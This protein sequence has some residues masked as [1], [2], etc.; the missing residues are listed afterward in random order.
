VRTDRGGGRGPARAARGGGPRGPGHASEMFLALSYVTA[1]LAQQQKATPAS[2]SLAGSPDARSGACRC[3]PG[4]RGETCSEVDLD[5]SVPVVRQGNWSWG[6]SPI[7]G[8]GGAVH[9]FVSVMA[10]GCGLLHYQTNSVV[11]H[12]VSESGAA[13]P[14]ERRGIAL[15]P[16]PG[17]W[18]S[19]AIHGPSIHYDGS[20]GLY[21]LFHAGFTH[22]GPKPNCTQDPTFPVVMVS[23]T[24]RIGVAWSASLDGPWER[25]DPILGPGPKGSWDSTDVSNAAP[26]VLPNG[27]VLLGF[28]AGVS[29]CCVCSYWLLAA[30]LPPQPLPPLRFFGVL[31][32]IL[33]SPILLLT[34]GG[35]MHGAYKSHPRRVTR[36]CSVVGLGSQSPITLLDHTAEFRALRKRSLLPR[37][38]GSDLLSIEQISSRYVCTATQIALL[39]PPPLL[40]LPPLLLPPDPPPLPCRYLWATPRG[41][42]MLVHAFVGPGSHRPGMNGVGGLAWSQDGHSWTYSASPSYTTAVAWQNGSVA[43]LYRRERPQPLIGTRGQTMMSLSKRIVMQTQC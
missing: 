22:P 10:E 7:L 14:F 18:D 9:L 21:L 26:C 1:A 33:T 34:I 28:R 2:C 11:E 32:T 41:F 29:A 27:T 42:H 19:G 5:Y 20:S 36:S 16:R 40:L 13:G 39:L 43:A 30:V 38:G 35:C 23:S 12:H 6:G 31:V 15:A 8:P 17:H 24:R 37:M 4:W 3:D 25:G